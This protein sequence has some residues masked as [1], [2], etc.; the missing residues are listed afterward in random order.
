M[1]AERKNLL[2]DNEKYFVCSDGEQPTKIYFDRSVFNLKNS[3]YIDSFDASGDLVRSYKFC[4][5]ISQYI[6]L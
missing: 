2:V 5:E 3:F 6:T 4:S 1:E